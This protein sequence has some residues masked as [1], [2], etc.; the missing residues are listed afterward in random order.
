MNPKL[1]LKEFVTHRWKNPRGNT[2]FRIYFWFVI[3]GIGAAGVWSELLPPV[4]RGQFCWNWEGVASGLYTFFPA[5][6]VSSAFDLVLPDNQMR[7]V[8][9][10]GLAVIL[11]AL[12][13][14][15]LCANLVSYFWAIIAGVAGSVGA[16]I[17][18]RIANGLNPS[19]QDFEPP[20]A[21]SSVGG[22]DS[23]PPAG[24]DAG[25]KLA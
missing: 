8:R 3:V 22:P 21:E 23:A 5:V 14:F 15:F 17:I 7:S 11:S 2:T 10:F 13:W 12:A 25:F 6:A 19:L 9:A 18:W 1:Q 24:S 4:V 16:L 20:R